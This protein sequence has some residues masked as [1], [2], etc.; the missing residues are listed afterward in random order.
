M[1]LKLLIKHH[2]EFLSLKGGYTCWKSYVTAHIL[3]FFRKH[4]EKI[5]DVAQVSYF[6][7]FVSLV[8][9]YFGEK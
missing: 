7:H 3:L 9:L 4:E 6:V 1:T 2:L 8:F 5:K